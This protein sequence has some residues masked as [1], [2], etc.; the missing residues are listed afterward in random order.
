MF[1]KFL[2]EII[3]ANTVEELN[4]IFYR[5]DGID[6]MYQRERI[7]WKDHETLLALINKLLKYMPEE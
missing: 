7:S 6:M 4:D 2:K 3:E 5:E 1:K